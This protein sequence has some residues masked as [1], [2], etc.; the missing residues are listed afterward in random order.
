MHISRNTIATVNNFATAAGVSALQQTSDD[1]S[2]T[3]AAMASTAAGTPQGDSFQS[4]FTSLLAAV[5]SGDVGTA[6]SALSTLQNAVQGTSAG[7][8]PNSMSSSTTNA[9][10]PQTDLAALFQAVKTGDLTSAQT[11]LTRLQTESQ[12]AAQ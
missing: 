9:A 1:S 12:S 2:A 7:Y 4:D 8:S 5:Q 11:A 10:A 3:T 6:Q